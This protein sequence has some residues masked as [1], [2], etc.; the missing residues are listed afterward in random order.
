MPTPFIRVS[1]LLSACAAPAPLAAGQAPPPLAGVRLTTGLSGA[2]YIGSPPRD[3]NRIFIAEQAGRIKIYKNGAVQ[4]T[5]F[6]D[7]STLTNMN[8]IEWGLLGV[9]FDPGY[10]T[11]RT[12]YIYHTDTTTAGNTVVARYQASLANPDIADPQTRTLVAV[13]PQTAIHHRA[14][15]MDFGADGHLYIALGD[16]GPE[17]DPNHKAQNLELLQGKIL[18]I[19]PYAD[20]FPA[21]PNNNY[22]IPTGNP[23]VGITG[24]DEIWAVGLRNPWRCAFDRLTGDIWIGDV[25]QAAKEE[26]DFLPANTPARNFGWACMEGF[27]CR[28]NI[29]CTCNTPALTLPIYD[30]PRTQ[31]VSITGGYVYRGCAIPGLQGTYFFSDWSSRK[32]WSLRRNGATYANF[33]DNTLIVQA[34]AGA[35]SN[36]RSFGEDA[37][38]EL[39]FTDGSALYKILP[40]TP[41][42]DCNANSRPDACD[43]YSGA[44]LDAN[45]N[46][47]PDE[48]E[49]CYPNCDGSTQPPVLNVQDFTCFLQRYAAGDIYANCDNSTQP[50]TL[51]VQDFTCFLQ[52]YAAGCP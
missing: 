25:G 11:N 31:G 14:G 17:G 22:S 28:N 51:N 32:L 43:I 24:R 2:L 20:D 13:I 12:F 30:Y 4:P 52:Q 39:L 46:G 44:S 5:L 8:W 26:V 45:L 19:N 38:G 47:V 21:D 3:F 34:G 35:W 29:D 27:D 33:T 7:I 40:G 9:A 23:F 1:L 48:C 41:I 50:P 36:V 16:G 42:T 18:R 49:S 37:Y 10:D 15:W 6:L